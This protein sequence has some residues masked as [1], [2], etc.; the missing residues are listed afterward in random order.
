[1]Q[2]EEIEAS[3]K[4]SNEIFSKI[5]PQC[6]KDVVLPRAYYVACRDADRQLRKFSINASVSCLSSSSSITSESLLVVI[7]GCYDRNQRV[8]YQFLRQKNL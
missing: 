5:M 4:V 7:G 2:P 8:S 6:A 1:M 3:K